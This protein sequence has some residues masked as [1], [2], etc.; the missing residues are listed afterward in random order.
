VESNQLPNVMVAGAHSM[1]ALGVIRS[2][3]KA[4]YI[5]HAASESSNETCFR[6]NYAHHRVIHPSGDKPEF[7]EWFENYVDTYNIK[8]IIPGGPISPGGHSIIDRYMHLFPVKNDANILAKSNKYELFESLLSESEQSEHLPPITLVNLNMELPTERNLS[9]LGCPLFIKLDR[10]HSINDQ[11]DQVIRLDTAIEAF[12][13]LSE[14]KTNY[15]KAVVQGFVQGSGVGVFLLR[16]D[17]VIKAKFMHRRLHEMPHTGG[18]S[19]LRESWW[20]DKILKDAEANLSRINW[21][22]VAMIE[23]RWDCNTDEFYL[24]EMNLRFWGSLHLA[25]YSGVDFPKLLADAFFGHDF[26]PNPK[27]EIGVKCR[28]T[29]PGEIG[30]IVSLWRDKNVSLFRKFY[31]ILELIWLSL[32]F[33]VKNDLLFPGDRKIFFY[34]L[35]QFLKTGQ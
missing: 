17:G 5:V 19:S 16:W 18:A 21:E 26:A 2:L 13:C 33:R 28:N 34:R 24:M 14:L 4:G 30:Y 8:L 7:K 20:H 31:S 3:G 10:V 35:M 12:S 6:S 11:G 27:P 1:G 23:Y 29:I 22:G 25:I 15:K 9:K 32:D